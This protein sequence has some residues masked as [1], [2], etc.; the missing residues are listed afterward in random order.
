MKQRNLFAILGLFVLALG[1]V[2]APVAAQD[3]EAAEE[4]AYGMPEGYEVTENADGSVTF[5]SGDDTIVVTSPASYSQ[6]LSTQEFES[7]VEE[8]TFFLDRAGYTAGVEQ[9]APDGVVAA[10]GASNSRRGQQGIAY[11]YDLGRERFAVVSMHTGRGQVGAPVADVATVASGF[12]YL[13]T[14]VDIA[15]ESAAGGDEDREGL[16]MLVEAV[17]NADSAVLE[18][19][20]GEGN[21]TV[22]APTNQ[23]FINLQATLSS[24]YGITNIFAD[25][26]Q[27][28]LTQVL[29]YHVVEG[30]VFAEDVLAVTG[31]SVLNTL[32]DDEQD[33]IV[34][35]FRDDGTA[36][37]NNTV[38]FVS[39][40]VLASNGVVHL[41]DDVLL[42]QCVID[43]LEGTGSCGA[44]AT[45]GDTEASTEGDS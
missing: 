35:T 32:L 3:E 25:A 1:I 22:F 21:Y 7:D 16:S 42:P 28:L 27:A 26:N 19:L 30:D 31:G 11:L 5:V 29:L 15:T 14:I 44:A 23:A 4:P 6:V 36:L 17:Q 18:T 34:V 43:T 8:L 33:G 10:V 45:D 24:E 9:N 2:F 38:D 20:S 13:G 41:I 37:L 12:T 40:D 39:T